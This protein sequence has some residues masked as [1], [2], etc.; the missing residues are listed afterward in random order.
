MNNNSKFDHIYDHK[1]T[2]LINKKTFVGHKEL[3]YSS[4]SNK[5]KNESLFNNLK[6]SIL[7]EKSVSRS[8]FK[9]KLD[10]VD[11]VSSSQKETSKKLTKIIK[12]SIKVYTQNHEIK[13]I[14][15]FNILSKK[16]C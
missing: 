5:R 13:M 11:F 14:N 7:I 6:N 10:F 16:N 3:I 9:S 15:Y 4:N 8:N 12:P 2:N 1:L